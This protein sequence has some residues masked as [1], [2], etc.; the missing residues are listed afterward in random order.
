MSPQTHR[1][2]ILRAAAQASSRTV[3]AFGARIREDRTRRHWTMRFL[4]E[5]AGI[6][7]GAVAL[8]EA[9]RPA[10]VATYARL[11]TALN[12]RL[13]LELTD[14]RRRNA[15]SSRDIDLV[16]AAMGE[17]EAKH[18]RSIGFEIDLDSPYQHYQF[19]GRA[20]VVAIDRVRSA[21]LHIENRTRFPDL[22]DAF[23]SY[24]A[25]RAY[26]GPELAE[27]HGMR[28]AWSS[29]THVMVGLWSAEVL[30]TLRIRTAS[31]HSVCPDPPDA[32]AAWWAGQPPEHGRASTFVILD[33]DPQLATSGR[34][35]R[36]RF[37]G[38]A[39]AMGTDPRYRGYA[40]AAN[41][42]R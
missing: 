30:H 23:G 27:R 31:F 12:L 29:E 28:G 34:S 41:A 10:S 40:E 32:F 4:A 37:V 21:L 25:K 39:D 38:I 1:E 9:G 22:Q 14:P 26:L 17:V 36:R 16:H 7:S 33:P 35:R 24:N 15:S 2:P 18:L 6:S 11:A 5:R 19:A 42:L 3:I 20:D 13:D 8:V